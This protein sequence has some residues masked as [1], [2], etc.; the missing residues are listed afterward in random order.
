VLGGDEEEERREGA[1]N[2]DKIYPHLAG[3]GKIKYN[4]R[5]RIMTNI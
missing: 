1:S 3:G 4:I 5:Y 2:S